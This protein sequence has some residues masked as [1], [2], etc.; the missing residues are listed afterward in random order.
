LRWGSDMSDFVPAVA[1]AREDSELMELVS[2]TPVPGA[3][4]LRYERSPSYLAG[5][6]TLGSV[7]EALILRHEPTG[8]IAGLACRSVRKLFVNGEP[9]DVGYLGQLRVDSSFRSRGLVAR[10]FRFIRD[11][12]KDKRLPGYITTLIE[13]NA[14][15]LGVL[16]DRPRPGM[17]RYRFVER[18]CGLAIPAKR[19]A[20]RSAPG[21]EFLRGGAF[22]GGDIAAFLRACGRRRQFAACYEEADFSADSG[23]TRG[24]DQA[25]LF[26]ATSGGGIVGTAGLWDQSAY[27]QTVVHGYSRLLSLARPWMNKLGIAGLPAPGEPLRMAYL[28]FLGVGEDDPVV[29]AGLLGRVLD[30]AARRG[31]SFVILGL[32]E[33]DPL[34]QPARNWRHAA[35]WSR[36]YT[37]GWEGQE[38]FHESLDGRASGVEFAAL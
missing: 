10:G 29:F 21:V 5:C 35:Y 3:V 4:S 16:V 23:L 37:V 31:I 17:P 30:L 36:L 18:L 22:P 6:G 15:A 28:S 7:S 34:L 1:S 14:E 26:V 20:P 38:T 11:L 12:D 19:Q 13:G 25:D 33:R 32:S 8:R 27:K 2:R 9:V 24:F